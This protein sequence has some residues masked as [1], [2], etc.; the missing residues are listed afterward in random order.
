MTNV[1]SRDQY[2]AVPDILTRLSTSK[3]DLEVALSLA[4]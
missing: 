2:L 4:G 1:K 3:F